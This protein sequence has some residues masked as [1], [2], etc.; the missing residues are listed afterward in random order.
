MCHRII[1]VAVFFSVFFFCLIVYQYLVNKDEYLHKFFLNNFI[2]IL[3]KYNLISD[4]LY[5]MQAYNEWIT[6]YRRA[7]HLLEISSKFASSEASRR[8]RR[9]T[10]LRFLLLIGHNYDLILCRP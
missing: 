3:T 2:K 9:Y 5:S 6:Y 1:C 4:L 8:D 10:T 7:L